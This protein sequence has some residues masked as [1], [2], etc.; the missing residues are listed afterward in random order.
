MLLTEIQVS[1][2][3]ITS[4]W[5]YERK[6]PYSCKCLCSKPCPVCYESGECF[7]LN[8][9]EKDNSS[10]E[11]YLVFRSVVVIDA[12]VCA[13]FPTYSARLELLCVL[14]NGERC[15]GKSC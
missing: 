6:D 8:V 12:E 11:K 7:S 1:V 5:P 10:D 9:K 2:L 13:S 15:S 3:D 4:L 14:F